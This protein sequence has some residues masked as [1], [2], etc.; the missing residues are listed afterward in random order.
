[1]SLLSSKGLNGRNHY[2]SDSHDSIQNFSPKKIFPIPTTMGW[3]CV[4]PLIAIW[5]TLMSQLI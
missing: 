5:K 2:S 4:L 3:V 1:M